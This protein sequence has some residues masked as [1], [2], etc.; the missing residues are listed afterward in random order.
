MAS[1]I[2]WLLATNYALLRSDNRTSPPLPTRIANKI[3]TR[4]PGSV[5]QPVESVRL[6]IRLA[7]PHAITGLAMKALFFFPLAY[8]AGVHGFA[9]FAPYAAF[10][11][12]VWLLAHKRKHRSGAPSKV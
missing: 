12:G 3:L 11:I 10:S 6:C 8:L 9:L 4:A 2:Y 1:H 5:R 7:W